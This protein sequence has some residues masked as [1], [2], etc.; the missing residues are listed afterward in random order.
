MSLFD[1]FI[2]MNNALGVRRMLSPTFGQRHLA[3]FSDLSFGFAYARCPHALGT[4]RDV[5]GGILGGGVG[6]ETRL[7]MVEAFRKSC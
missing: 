1:D 3:F 4:V 2:L 5:I 6:G 7:W